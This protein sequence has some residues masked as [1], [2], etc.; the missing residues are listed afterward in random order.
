VM[1]ITEKRRSRLQRRQENTRR[2]YWGKKGLN[3]LA[4]LRTTNYRYFGL[5]FIV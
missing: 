4:I 3:L 5:P 2:Q 1:A